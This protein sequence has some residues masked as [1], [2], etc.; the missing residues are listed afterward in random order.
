MHRNDLFLWQSDYT[1][2]VTDEPLDFGPGTN[3]VVRDMGSF[4]LR[5]HKI[6]IDVVAGPDRGK[7]AVLPGPAATVGSGDECD[8]TLTDPTVSRSHVHLRIERDEIRV[9]DTGSRNGTIVDGLRVMDA[10]ARPDSS[11]AIGN[12]TLR[13][14][15]LSDTVDVPL[16]SSTRFGGLIG[17]SVPMRQLFAILE[18]VS[19]TETTVLIEGE[20][21]TGKE[22]IAEAVHDGSRR[23]DGPFVVFDCSAITPQLVES[24]LFGHKKGAFTGA[25]QDRVGAIEAAHHG[26]LFLDEIGELPL[27]LQPKLLRALERLEV[28]P[29][30]THE[31]RR[32][33]VR[34]VAA[35]NR[36]L[37]HMVDEGTFREDLYYR[38]A[39][40]RVV[41][42][43]LRERPHD[44]PKLIEHFI[45]QFAGRHGAA[46]ELPERAVQGFQTMAWPGNV[47][48]LRN[49]V[50][51]ALSLG[52]PRDL[53]ASGEITIPSA[54]APD[55]DLS[56]PLKLAKEQISDAFE[57]AYVTEA[58]KASGG[59]VTRAAE[60]AGVNRKY[61]HRAIRHHGLRDEDDEGNS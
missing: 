51:R 39:V 40:V 13:L 29:V 61:I 32:V 18:R 10:F 59:V 20:T 46:S 57:R 43:P 15:L 49:A 35:T 26:T 23:A 21:G 31:R 54:G 30:G 52:P 8:L 45:A 6:H 44:I 9:L 58:L 34:I 12:T 2:V 36:S 53:R 14:Q 41:A 60:I 24:E 16:S 17:E 11:I 1:E 19:P 25:L 56:V 55:V 42:P 27:D 38:L 28:S 7:V 33:D 37:A 3:S 22:L 48:E 4:K 5:S 50:A 47:R